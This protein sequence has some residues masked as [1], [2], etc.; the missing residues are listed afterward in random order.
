LDARKQ[1]S[2]DAPEQPSK[3]ELRARIRASGSNARADRDLPLLAR[4][5]LRPIR[6]QLEY[7]KPELAFEDLGVQNTIVVFG[8]TRLLDPEIARRRLAEAEAGRGA[9]RDREVARA[10]TA[11]EQ[12]RYYE[13]GRELGRLVGRCGQGPG[14]NRLVVVT[15]GGPGGMEAANRGAFDVGAASVGLNITLPMEQAPNPYITPELSFQFRYFALR[16]LHFMLRAR[17]LVALPGGY[18]TFDELFETLC[19]VQTGKRSPLPV[20]L[21][22][23]EFWRRAVDFDYLVAAGMIDTDDLDLFEFVETAQ[24][25]WDRSLRWYEERNES[26][27]DPAPEAG[28]LEEDECD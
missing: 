12:S 8:G 7:L 23:E 2:G 5:E 18:G 21:V 14:D 10:R 9:D 25:V 22:G 19:L 17:A 13:I 20:M 28:G 24:Q 26:I 27:F 4:P 15:G 6:L 1:P 16:K 11:V 3:E